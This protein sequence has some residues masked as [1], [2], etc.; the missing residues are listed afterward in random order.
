MGTLR[1]DRD[2]VNNQ[3]EAKTDQ[4][5]WADLSLRWAPMSQGTFSFVGVNTF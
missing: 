1:V 2:L 4:T 3:A 5:S